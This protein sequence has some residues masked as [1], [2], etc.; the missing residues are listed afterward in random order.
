MLFLKALLIELKKL[1]I[2]KGYKL[3]RLGEL[4]T[5]ER[6]HHES[7]VLREETVDA[8]RIFEEER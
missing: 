7:E 1:V 3:P 4:N 2:I 5:A 8:Q 6:Q